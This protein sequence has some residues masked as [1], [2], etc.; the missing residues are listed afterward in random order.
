MAH[1]E[2]NG[3]VH[4]DLAARNI[5]VGQ[6]IDVIKVQ[7]RDAYLSRF[8]PPLKLADF[9]LARCLDDSLY[10]KNNKG[11]IPYKWTAPEAL[12]IFG[13]E[14][15]IIQVSSDRLHAYNSYWDKKQLYFIYSQASPLPHLMPG[16]SQ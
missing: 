9:G 1:L 6:S 2:K 14:N 15:N 11:G 13:A 12:L 10:Y 8:H 4:R 16:A 5:L 7:L 3:I